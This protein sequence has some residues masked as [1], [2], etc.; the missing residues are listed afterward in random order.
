MLLLL[1]LGSAHLCHQSGIAHSNSSTVA[2]IFILKIIFSVQ[3][4]RQHRIATPWPSPS[5]SHCCFR[6]L[7]LTA[8]YEGLV[9]F[10]DV[11][12]TPHGSHS[13][14]RP[15]KL[16]KGSSTPSTNCKRSTRARFWLRINI[17]PPRVKMVSPSQARVLIRSGGSSRAPTS[18]F[19]TRHICWRWH[20]IDHVGPW[21]TSSRHL[22]LALFSLPPSAPHA[23]T[24]KSE[25]YDDSCSHRGPHSH[26]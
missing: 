4:A 12:S 14:V 25:Y 22:C 5:S 17:L 24:D 19:T 9:G 18:H 8:L 1:L 6:V 21:K 13:S 26:R 11:A 20:C 16:G 10:V 3:V 7:A 23:E 2:K 15:W